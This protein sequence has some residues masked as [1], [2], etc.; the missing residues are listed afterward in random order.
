[1][2]ENKKA[3]ADESRGKSKKRSRKSSSISTGKTRGSSS[4]DSG[5]CD[6]EPATTTPN[7]G[8]RANLTPEEQKIELALDRKFAMLNDL[9]P[10]EDRPSYLQTREDIREW[11]MGEVGGSQGWS[12]KIRGDKWA[13]RTWGVGQ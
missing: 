1:M 5:T 11:S 9:W 8:N 7:D 2:V 12:H 13:Y 10:Q 4:E 3:K 6:E